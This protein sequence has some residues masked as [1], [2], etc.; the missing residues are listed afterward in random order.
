MHFRL[1]SYRT[2]KVTATSFSRN[3]MNDG[4]YIVKIIEAALVVILVLLN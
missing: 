3:C 2:M 4:E 1:N